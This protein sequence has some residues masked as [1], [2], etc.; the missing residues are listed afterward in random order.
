MLIEISN[1]IQTPATNAPT[2]AT[3]PPTPPPTTKA[4]E[5]PGNGNDIGDC[6]DVVTICIAVNSLLNETDTGTN[7]TLGLTVAEI[8]LQVSSL[9]QDI[10]TCVSDSSS[11]SVCERLAA[12]E[13]EINDIQ[14]M[15]IEISNI[16]QTPA[17]DAPTQ[18][19]PPPTPKGTKAPGKGGG[20]DS[21]KGSTQGPT[22]APTPKATKAPGKG[23]ATSTATQVVTSP[24]KVK[25]TKA[26][27][28]RAR[29]RR[30]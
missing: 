2:Q 26:P 27:K 30:V 4:T 13:D 24:P 22:P 3:P 23:G 25:A 8:A 20:K 28:R 10:G 17:T 14:G 19:T 15:L 29:I 21:N 7:T 12:L 1:I 18:A 6:S 11:S 9:S 5:A 16:I